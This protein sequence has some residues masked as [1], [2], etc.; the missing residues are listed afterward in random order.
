[1]STIL[2]V[3]IIF[4]KVFGKQ[5]FFVVFLFCHFVGW[6]V[7]WLVVFS[8][9]YSGIIQNVFIF[10]IRSFELTLGSAVPF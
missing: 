3:E 1:M 9:D 7:G 4:V 8:E 5:N 10:H 2:I 6:L